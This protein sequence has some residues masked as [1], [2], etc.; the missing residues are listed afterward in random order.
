MR[1]RGFPFRRLHLQ[2]RKASPLI[3]HLAVFIHRITQCVPDS[4]ALPCSPDA[5]H[6][7]PPSVSGCP[8]ISTCQP[9]AARRLPLFYY[10][11]DGSISPV[12]YYEHESLFHQRP[13]TPHYSSPSP[14]RNPDKGQPNETI[15]NPSPLARKD[16]RDQFCYNRIGSQWKL[17][18]KVWPL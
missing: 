14:S 1:W 5:H 12:K 9:G 8:L 11:S 7:F 10:P 18:F 17:T 16:L 15:T 13:H 4:P 2:S 6:L 3:S